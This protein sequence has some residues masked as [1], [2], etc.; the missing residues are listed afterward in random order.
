MA[1]ECFCLH[2]NPGPGQ[3]Y[4]YSPAFNFTD[5]KDKA[6]K[7][8]LWF[9]NFK[10]LSGNLTRKLP[11]MYMMQGKQHYPDFQLGDS[12]VLTSRAPEQTR[13]NFFK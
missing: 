7:T 12:V 8:S 9:Y 10:K 13:I 11:K 1:I 4:H 5:G 6:T 2:A 3:L